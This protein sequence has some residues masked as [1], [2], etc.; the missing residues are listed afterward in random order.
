M[1]DVRKRTVS[2]GVQKLESQ[3]TNS[4]YRERKNYEGEKIDTK[5]NG[6]E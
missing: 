3:Y 2:F 1:K 6:W 4:M 5:F